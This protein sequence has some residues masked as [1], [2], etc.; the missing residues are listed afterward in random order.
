MWHL[1]RNLALPLGMG[2]WYTV[3]T[4]GYTHRGACLW[5]DSNNC[6]GV[7][8]MSVTT[9]QVL[10]LASLVRMSLTEA[11][12]NRL[13]TELSQVLEQFQALE[14]LQI[15]QEAK[16]SHPHSKRSVLRSDQ[17]LGEYSLES[18]LQNAPRVEENLIRGKAILD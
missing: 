8:D 18:M 2:V 12:V 1:L 3:G 5:L 6:Q 13:G 14:R 17:S 9:E 11:E 7:Q 4:G 16:A 10:H 15:P